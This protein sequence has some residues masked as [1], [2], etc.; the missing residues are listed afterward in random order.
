MIIKVKGIKT[1]FEVL[2]DGKNIIILHG[3]GDNLRSWHNVQ[4]LLSKKF[5]VFTIDLPGFGQSDLP[6]LPWGIQNYSKFLRD[7][8][9]ELEIKKPILI[10]HSF[11][12]KITAYFA[13]ENSDLLNKIILVSAQGVESKSIRAKIKIVIFKLL[14][15]I[16]ILFGLKTDQLSQKF[17]SRDYRKAGKLRNT[18]IKIVNQNIKDRLPRIKIPTLIIWGDKD[19]EL[20]VKNSKMFEKLIPN[21]KTRI[22]WNTGHFCHIEQGQT[23]VRLITNFVDEHV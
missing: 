5:R 20:S 22:V 3:W 6:K 10:G 2:G 11:G 7:F 18:F 12:G 15:K 9:S 21:S 4:N 13:S 19:K 1:N 8:I 14:K 23:L 16:F 17:G